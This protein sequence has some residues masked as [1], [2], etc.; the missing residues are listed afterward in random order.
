MKIF[1][2]GLGPGDPAYLAP[3]A[4]LAISESQVVVG[5]TG[6]MGMVADLVEGKECISTGMRG[7]AARCQSAIEEALKGKLVSVI[8]SGDAGIYGMASLLYELAAQ[9]PEIEIEVVP[10]ITAA[11]SA[12]AILGS[13]LTNDFAVI[14]LSDLLT[15]WA[16]IEKRL[17]TCSQG[18]LVICLYNPQSKKRNDHLKRACAIVL[19]HQP[20][21]T[22]CGYV[23][24]AYR[25]EGSQSQICTLDELSRAEV[26]M[27]TTVIIG[28]S[29]TR[30][31]NNKLVTVR[32]YAV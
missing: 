10:G 21:Q 11:A 5:Y 2:I 4:R 27:F 31:I 6:Y 24:N 22:N 30:V 23:R 19:E 25:A 26:D 32:G 20:G 7:E 14:S 18:D 8:C 28:N 3:R 29:G 15:P 1:A 17:R 16:V 12:A 9:H 13:P